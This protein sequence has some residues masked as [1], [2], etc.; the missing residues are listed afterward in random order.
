MKHILDRFEVPDV[1]FNYHMQ[2][3]RECKELEIE[4]KE[5]R[6][7]EVD[8]F[9]YTERPPWS[10]FDSSEDKGSHVRN[11]KRKTI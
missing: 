4:Q 8:G 10:G 6:V 9:D 5:K 7:W 3:L 2:S 11:D 1:D